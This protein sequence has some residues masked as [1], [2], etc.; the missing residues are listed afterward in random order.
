MTG[1]IENCRKCKGIY[2]V[3]KQDRLPGTGLE[4]RRNRLQTGTGNL[5]GDG[6]VCYDDCGNDCMGVN[7]SE[8]NCIL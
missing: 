8:L 4:G 2:I 7:M 3:S 5:E 1:F 6:T